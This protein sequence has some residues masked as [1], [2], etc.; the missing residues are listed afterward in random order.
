MIILFEFSY[1]HNTLLWF[2]DIL[3]CIFGCICLKAQKDYE[4]FRYIY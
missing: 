3:F 2:A 4:I 1:S